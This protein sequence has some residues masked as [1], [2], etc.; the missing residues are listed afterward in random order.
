MSLLTCERTASIVRTHTHPGLS[1][2]SKSRLPHSS[3]QAQRPLR[4]SKY[5]RESYLES[6][7][8]TAQR[9]PSSHHP[10]TEAIV[11]TAW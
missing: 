5:K 6:H 8:S 3:G 1:R 11:A 7:P 4:S 2:G 9:G 10:E